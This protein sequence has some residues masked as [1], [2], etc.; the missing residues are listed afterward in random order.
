MDPQHLHTAFYSVVSTFGLLAMG[1]QFII[2][3]YLATLLVGQSANGFRR[4][5]LLQFKGYF[6]TNLSNSLR[7]LEPFIGWKEHQNFPVATL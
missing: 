1:V 4:S 7:L 3:T 6:L 2:L 5:S